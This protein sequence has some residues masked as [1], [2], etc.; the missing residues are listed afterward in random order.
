MVIA[1]HTGHI[2]IDISLIEKEIILFLIDAMVVAMQTGHITIDIM[3]ATIDA[4]LIASNSN[5]AHPNYDHRNR[6]ITFS[7]LIFGFWQ[8]INRHRQSA[9]LYNN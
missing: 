7:H 3:Q 5:A 4:S 6:A 8:A 1:L 2:A 9:G